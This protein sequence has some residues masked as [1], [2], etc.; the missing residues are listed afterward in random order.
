[1]L[2]GLIVASV[3]VQISGAAPAQ[4]VTVTAGTVINGVTVV[5]TRDE[6]LTPGVVVIVDNGKIVRIPGPVRSRSA[7][8]DF[9][10]TK[11]SHEPPS[12]LQWDSSPTSS[13]SEDVPFQS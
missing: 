13:I 10:K 3:A 4:D 6:S 2:Q 7:D 1:M 9:L 5:N 8:L 12:A 11:L